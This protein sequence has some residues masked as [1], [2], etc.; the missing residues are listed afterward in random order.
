MPLFVNIGAELVGFKNFLDHSTQHQTVLSDAVDGQMVH[1]QHAL[2]QIKHKLDRGGRGRIVIVEGAGEFHH[3]FT[4]AGR[5]ILPAGTAEETVESGTV[6]DA[7][8]GVFLW[9][10]QW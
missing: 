7:V 4:C 3:I 2:I 1:L 8:F 9:S 6:G 10:L 5:E